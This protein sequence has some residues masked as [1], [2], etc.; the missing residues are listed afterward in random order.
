VASTPRSSETRNV[1]RAT[2]GYF[3]A[4]AVFSFAAN[5]LYLA[6][7]LYMLQVYDRVVSS[8]S[9]TTLVMLTIALLVALAAMAGLDA[10][11]ARVLT[12]AGIRLDRMLGERVVEAA[13]EDRS[14]GARSQPL[15]DLDTFRQFVSGNGVIALFDL[16]WSP[17]YVGVIFLL[18]PSLGYFA[19]GCVIVLVVL[20]LLNE[21]LI[22]K[23]LIE[24]QE[25]TSRSYHFTDMSLRNSDVVRSMGMTEG[26]IRRWSR[27]RYQAL[28]RHVA[29]SDRSSGMTSL[30]KFL[31]LAM[32]SLVLGIGAFLVVTRAASA[33]IMFAAMVLLGRALQPIEQTVGQWRSLV[34]ARG[35]WVRVRTLLENHPAEPRVLT[36]PRPA[37]HL[38]VEGL[39]VAVPGSGRPILK[40][41]T[42]G[43][44]AGESLGI[45]GPSGAGKTT[46]ARALVGV[47]APDAGAVRLDGA[48]VAAW[49]HKSLGRHLGYLPQDIDLFAGTVAANIG[50]FQSD[51]D[52]E[53]LNAAR[54]AGIHE[55][56]LRLPNGYETEAGEAGGILSGGY[57]QRIALA[58][59]VFGNPSLVVLDEPSSNLDADG[60]QALIQCL[61]RLKANGTTTI[62][63]SH[64][65]TA[66][67]AVDKI[68]VLQE[69]V[70]QLFGSRDTII[71]RIARPA[72][73]QPGPAVIGPVAVAGR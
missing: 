18:H 21:R 30:I 9:V 25:S 16:P 10:V 34:A 13:L 38:S 67:A 70:V 45:V 37:G 49:P 59:A 26:L 41:V 3:V 57:R 12:R 61:Q 51:A 22:R 7:P 55:T 6:A 11:R 60:D 20:A 73:A 29:A 14:G 39:T 33:G 63:I 69:G 65:P 72:A 4:A 54:L 15:R 27:D 19:A 44:D 47:L 32:Q 24:A 23:P 48:E 2:R 50:R 64:R 35:A 58:R 1:F 5:L 71:G 42:F 52:S 56:I 31:R 8:G 46:L 28:D 62:V 36:L 68:L 66:L 17:I 53:I 43:L 40:N